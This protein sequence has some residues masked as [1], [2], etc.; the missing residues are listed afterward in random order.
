MDRLIAIFFALL[1]GGSTAI[2]A[3]VN[4]RLG[5]HTTA[6][7]ATFLSLVVGAVFILINIIM[8]GEV[9]D[10]LTLKEISPKFFLGGIFGCLI[11]YFTIKAIPNLGT[12][13]TLV[14]IVVSQV[15]ISLFLEVKILGTEQMHLYKYI[16][17]ILLGIGTF[18]VV[19]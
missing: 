12:S 10:L 15:V 13:N 9:R 14:M 18:F 17:V 8:T 16:G 11:I 5:R 4:G 2:E 6:L 7:V 3:Y 19:K 1:A